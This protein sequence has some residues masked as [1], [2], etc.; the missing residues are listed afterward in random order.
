MSISSQ[1][2]FV[3]MVL[4][5]ST[6]TRGQICRGARSRRFLRVAVDCTRELRDLRSSVL[7]RLAASGREVGPRTSVSLSF[8]QWHLSFN[9]ALCV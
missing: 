2:V 4:A 5:C 3:M 1:V 9:K 8:N 6:R 7:I